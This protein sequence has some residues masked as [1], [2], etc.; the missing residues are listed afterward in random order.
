[1]SAGGEGLVEAL[2]IDFADPYGG[3]AG[4]ARVESTPGK[5]PTRALG[6]LVGSDGTWRS[7]QPDTVRIEDDGTHARAS[8]DA[9]GAGFEIEATRGGTAAIGA[10]TAFADAAGVSR[11]LSALR[12]TG[13][14]SDGES[15]GRLDCTGTLARTAGTP[16]WNRIALMRSLS[17][18]LEDGSLLAVAAARPEGAAGHGEEAASAVLLDPEGALTGFD[19][20][21]VSTEYDPEG[22]PRRIGV[23]LWSSDEDGAPLRGAGTLIGPAA[24]VALLRFTLDGSPG[25]A[26]YELVKPDE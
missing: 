22:R 19:E 10:G 3:V 4:L 8:L 6:V 15:G 16:D 1:M 9:G 26:R 13:R 20:P 11:E 17:A 23:E 24:D 21:L 2:S 12:V 18:A 7:V 14:W 5:E 25:T